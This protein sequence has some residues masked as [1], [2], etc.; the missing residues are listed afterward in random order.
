MEPSLMVP[1]TMLK[2]WASNALYMVF[3]RTK[4][5]FFVM[6]SKLAINLLLRFCSLCS[7]VPA[8]N[9][10]CCVS[11]SLPQEYSCHLPRM[12]A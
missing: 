1:F 6:H 2:L 12:S 3:S 11:A 7:Q 8:G 10:S 4:A 9:L 5:L